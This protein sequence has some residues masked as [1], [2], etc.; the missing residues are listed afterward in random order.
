MALKGA[1]KVEGVLGS[2][3]RR[4]ADNSVTGLIDVRVSTTTLSG[5]GTLEEFVFTVKRKY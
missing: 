2:G 3:V 1:P 4:N 5:D